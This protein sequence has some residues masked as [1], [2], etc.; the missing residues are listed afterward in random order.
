MTAP[1]YA[2][3]ALGLALALA[4]SCGFSR[5]TKGEGEPCTRTTE[6]E[7]HLEC[8]GGVCMRIVPDAGSSRDASTPSDAAAPDAASVDAAAAAPADAATAVPDAAPVD[9]AE[10]IDGAS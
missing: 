2:L 5:D 3:A 1:K 4:R 6:C 10:A 7:V 8:R 9:A